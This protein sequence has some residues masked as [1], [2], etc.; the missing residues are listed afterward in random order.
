[1]RRY[2]DLYLNKMTAML[3]IDDGSP[4]SKA[5]ADSFKYFFKVE[6]LR[7]ITVGEYRVLT[8][9]YSCDNNNYS[10]DKVKEL[11][12]VLS[13]EQKL[14]FANTTVVVN[15]GRDGYRPSI[16]I[17]SNGGVYEISAT[18]EGKFKISYEGPV[19]YRYSKDGTWI[20]REDYH[21]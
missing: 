12:H 3:E 6:G 17:I 16:T 9:Q 5:D 21:D 11:G 1:M 19:G 15:N 13:E 10:A 4:A 18:P 8:A 14:T 20:E 2:F 7:E